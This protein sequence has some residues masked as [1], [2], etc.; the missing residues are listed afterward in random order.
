MVV[1]NRIADVIGGGLELT[2]GNNLTFLNGR[3]LRCSLAR[4]ALL[5]RQA[6]KAWHINRALT[7]HK[8]ALA[9]FGKQTGHDNNWAVARMQRGG[10]PRQYTVVHTTFTSDQR[11]T[12]LKQ[13][14]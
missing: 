8:S 4:R 13:T 7:L 12:I 14:E 5:G 11:W 3:Q 2:H 10:G 6:E 9:A 1:L